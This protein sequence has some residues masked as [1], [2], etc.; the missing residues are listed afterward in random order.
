M[1]NDTASSETLPAVWCLE[2][3]FVPL[4]TWL[5]G[6]PLTWP[7]TEVP[8][9][10]IQKKPRV[11]S[12]TRSLFP[13]NLNLQIVFKLRL[14][15]RPYIILTNIQNKPKIHFPQRELTHFTTLEGTNPITPSQN[16][17]KRSILDKVIETI[18][19]H[20]KIKENCASF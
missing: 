8:P 3:G 19:L 15:L 18:Y 11:N 1:A 2:T 6:S 16:A 12:F 5:T 14:F 13:L 20:L 9:P 10:R 7:A 17:L 4:R